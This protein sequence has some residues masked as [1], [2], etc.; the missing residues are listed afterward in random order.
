MTIY[1]PD[2]EARGAPE[3]LAARPMVTVKEHVSSDA[4]WNRY[5]EIFSHARFEFEVAGKHRKQ[6]ATG[7]RV[8]SVG[9]NFDNYSVGGWTSSALANLQMIFVVVVFHCHAP[10]VAIDSIDL[11]FDM[12]DRRIAASHGRVGYSVRKLMIQRYHL[13]HRRYVDVV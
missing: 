13:P 7:A 10:Q 6:F 12:A 8:C 2:A 11:A 5:A 4:S 1:V 9:R 3:N